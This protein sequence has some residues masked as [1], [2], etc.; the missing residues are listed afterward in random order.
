MDGGYAQSWFQFSPDGNTVALLPG[1]LGPLVNVETEE[2]IPLIHHSLAQA[3]MQLHGVVWHLSGD[4]Y[5][6][7]EHIFYAGGGGGPEAMTLYS[8]DGTLRRELGLCF[9]YATCAGFVPERA[10][11]YLGNG[12]AHSV[13]DEPLLTLQH[14]QRIEAVAWNPHDHLL[15]AYGLSLP[16][17]SDDDEAT[18]TIWRVTNT[19]AHEVETYPVDFVC[20]QHPGGSCLMT[21]R[22]DNTILFDNQYDAAWVLDLTT[23]EVQSIPRAYYK[24]SP[25]GLYRVER[26]DSKFTIV[27]IER[28][29]IVA[30]V[31]REEDVNSGFLLSCWLP[32]GHTLLVQRYDGRI[33]RW[34]G[35]DIQPIGSGAA[36]HGYAYHEQAE[37]MATGSLYNRVS[38][39]DIGAGKHLTDINWASSAL[40]F[41][42]DGSLL[43]AGGTELVSIWDMTRY[44][45]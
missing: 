32:E 27:A 37:L 4:W 10:A 44:R 3:G 16:P 19:E 14:D 9:S 1:I 22:D 33:L 12:Q 34:D 13:V 17:R 40:A 7:G 23:H 39:I 28:D 45:H 43:A 29:E 31:E 38:I 25:D 36:M 42:S 18:L 15:A 2:K 6:T 41:N 24:I 11:P 30:E 26:Y 35:T 21:W 5:M 20:S 8:R